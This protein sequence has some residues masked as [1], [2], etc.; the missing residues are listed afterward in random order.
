[1]IA[2]PPAM[3]DSIASRLPLPGMVSTEGVSGTVRWLASED[4]RDITGHVV[5]VDRGYVAAGYQDPLP[6][7]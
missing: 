5:P 7:L 3:E 6:R 1:M 4:A 2:V